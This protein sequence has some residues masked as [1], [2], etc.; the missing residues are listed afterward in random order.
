VVVHCYLGEG[1]EPQHAYLG[2]AAK[3]RLDLQGCA[4]IALRLPERR[5]RSSVAP[6]D[7][8]PWGCST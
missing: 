8:L 7:I 6:P 4:V 3:L 5:G 1:G 2:E